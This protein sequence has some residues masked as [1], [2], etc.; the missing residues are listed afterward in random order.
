MSLI[1]GLT[2]GIASG[3]STVT[4]MFLDL[5]IPVIDADVEARR[6]VEKGENAYQQIVETFG[7]EIVAVDGEIDRGK[8]GTIVFH[9][10]AKR[11]QLNAIVH[12]A[13]RER[14]NS[15]KERLIAAGHPVV[16]LDIPLLFESKLTHL[17]EKVLLVY[18]GEDV[19]LQRLMARNGLPKNDALARIHSQ[20]PLKDK[21]SLADEVIN[22]NGTV[23]ETQDQLL[24]ILENWKVIE[25]A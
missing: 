12:P 17:V 22:N 5:G 11:L 25:T 1:I 3:K 20:M 23:D 10:E 6:V 14:M 9:N 8:L 18:V 2:G 16:V 15:E 21:I 4:R 19:Q 13:V 24:R 7:E